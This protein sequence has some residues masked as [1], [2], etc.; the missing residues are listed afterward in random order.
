[1]AIDTLVVFGDSWPAGGELQAPTVDAFPELLSKKLNLR[2][3]NLSQGGT[4]IDQAVVRF[5]DNSDKLQNS[6][7]AVLFCL[8]S[9]ARSMYFSNEH[10][11]EIH[12]TD[13]NP[14]SLNYYKYIHSKQLSEFNLIR[15]MLLIQEL[16]NRFGTP[17]FFVFNWN[18]TVHHSLLDQNLV[19]PESLFNM[20]DLQ[21]IEQESNK[22]FST[23]LKLSKYIAPNIAHPNIEGHHVLSAKIYNWIKEKL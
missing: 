7:S 6:N 19:C 15:N 20:L 23:Q 2:L 16:C 5:L 12:P 1:M 22:N 11:V 10:T 9:I 8:T 13:T 18:D 14:T 3:V 21:N 4:S 17:V